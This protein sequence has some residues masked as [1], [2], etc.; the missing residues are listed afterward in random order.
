MVK[1]SPFNTLFA[2]VTFYVDVIY[3]EFQCVCNY[4]PDT[5][6]FPG[7]DRQGTP[8]GYMYKFDCKP[9]ELSISQDMHRSAAGHNPYNLFI[10]TKV[11]SKNLPTS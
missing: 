4:D 10:L 11:Y 3:A 6:V 8:I 1:Y 2:F 7:P 9:L 5:P